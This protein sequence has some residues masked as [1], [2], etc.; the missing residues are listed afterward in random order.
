MTGTIAANALRKALKDAPVPVRPEAKP[1]QLAEPMPEPPKQGIPPEQTPLVQSGAELPVA[2]DLLDTDLRRFD[3]D[4][5]HHVNF[6]LI[7]TTDEIK[8]TIGGVAERNKGAIDEARRDVITH[9]NLKGLAEDLNMDADVIGAVMT[10]EAGGTLNAETILAARQVL[11]QSALRTRTLAQ[12]IKAGD[13]SDLDKLAFRRQFQWHSEYQKQFMGARAEA[14]RALGAFNIPVGTDTMQLGR[15]NE[16]ADSVQGGNLNEMAE[17]VLSADSLQGINAA[18]RGYQGSRA[19][20]AMQELFIN[21]ILSG[22]KTHVVNTIGNPLFHVMNI[23]ET[24]LAAQIGKVLPGEAHVQVGEASAM[25]YGSLASWRDALRVAGKAMKSGNAMDNMTKFEIGHTPAISS[26]AFP[27]TKRADEWLKNQFGMET[28]IMAPALDMLGSVVRFPTERLLT[29]EDEFAKTFLYRS[30]ISQMAAR[31]AQ[32]Q[33]K[34]GTMAAAD[35]PAF[36]NKFM[37]SP[38]PEALKY[39]EDAAQYG[40]FQTPLGPLGQKWQSIIN[41]TP[42]LKFIAPFVRTPVNLFKAGL[43]ERGPTALFS[44][45]FREQLKNGGPERDMAMARLSM[46]SLTAATVAVA[47]G[48]GRITGGGPSNPQARRLLEATGWQPYSI[49]IE[50]AE[51]V[52]Y[53]S[54]MRAEPLAFV[55][56]AVADATEILSHVDF[57]DELTPEEEQAM[58]MVSAVV[59]GIAENTTSKTFLSGISDFIQVTEEPDRYLNQW[60]QNTGSAF[61]PYS[62]LRRDISK[63]S[64]PYIRE[65]WEMGDKVRQSSGIPGMSADLPLSL[66]IY[67]NPR[68]Y[69]RGAIMGV[70]SPFPESE[71]TGTPLAHNLVELMEQSNKVPITAPNRRID[72]LRLSASEYQAYVN[73]SRNTV[74][75]DGMDF[76]GYLTE[77]MGSDAYDAMGVDG[78]VDMLKDVQRQFDAQAKAELIEQYDTGEPDSLAERLRKRADVKAERKYGL[79]A[80]LQ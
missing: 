57:E 10:R 68:E 42:G 19:T 33:V 30:A 43:G 28:P 46:G 16:L 15:M 35:A 8:A 3:P 78:K 7:T 79:E 50:T 13:A 51:G 39:A 47:V 24:A 80:L 21:S 4:E 26:A 9:E 72:G 55:I 23:S 18:T 6:D 1:R 58:K 5:S 59:A 48:D 67:G 44:K 29:A 37:S 12:K 34:A 76:E 32:E 20:G 14:G 61:I 74:E 73:L 71:E 17:L 62:A 36:I 75:I 60:L 40:T 45:K 25:L 27:E 38:P 22:I 2:E 11:N 69:K 52:T 54:Y 53:Q 77:V 66:D 70:I 41:Q 49:R 56:G 65:A 64:D 31:Q 63:I